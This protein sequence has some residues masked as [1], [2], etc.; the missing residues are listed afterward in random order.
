MERALILCTEGVIRGD[1][2]PP[3]L[4]TG[5]S[6]HNGPGRAFKEHMTN[7]EREIIVEELRRSRGNMAKA[8]RALDL[9]ERVMGLRVAAYAI[10]TGTFK[11]KRLGSPPPEK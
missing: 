3:N 4:Q 8:A 1:H 9:T 5:R 6:A 11:Q 7:L 10:D 2:L